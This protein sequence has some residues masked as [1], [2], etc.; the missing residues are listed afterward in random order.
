MLENQSSNL[1]NISMAYRRCS[2]LYSLNSAKLI[3][4]K[5]VAK[6]SKLNALNLNALHTAIELN[7]L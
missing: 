6:L 4:L 7:K 5:I 2:Y 1:I 3:R